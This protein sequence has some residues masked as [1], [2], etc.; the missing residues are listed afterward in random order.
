LA[1]DRNGRDTVV[2]SAFFPTQSIVLPVIWQGSRLAVLQPPAPLAQGWIEAVNDAGW[3]LGNGHTTGDLQP[4]LKPPSA[5]P[6]LLGLPAGAIQCRLNDLNAEGEAIGSA[7]FPADAHAVRWKQGSYTDLGFI[8]D[9]TS[10]EMRRLNRAGTAVGT[11]AHSNHFR[12]LLAE[13]TQLSW[14]DDRLDP[15][16]AS[17]E[18]HGGLD[19]ANDGRILAV[20]LDTTTPGSRAQ[21][22]VLTPLP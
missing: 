2:G 8:A 17:W 10:T 18:I 5:A 13:G 12:G 19:I 14:L 21:L 1:V 20:A 15:A 7:Y 9:S 16:A 11:A 6:V 4:W 22:V 3:M